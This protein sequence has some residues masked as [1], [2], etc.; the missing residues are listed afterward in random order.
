VVKLLSIRLSSR[1]LL[2]C[3]TSMVLSSAAFAQF[4]GGGFTIVDNGG[5]VPASCSTVPVSGIAV[6]RTITNISFTGVHT[7][8]GDTETRVYPPGAAPPPSTAGSVVISSPPDGRGCNFNGTYN[9]NDTASQSVDAATV[10]C[11][12][13]SDLAPGSYRTSTYG[14]GVNPGP[15]TSL[16]ASFGTLTPAQANGNWLVCIFDFASPDGGAVSSTLIQFNVLTAAN[17]SLSGRVTTAT[18]QGITRAR[19]IISDA[20]GNPRIA[21]TNAFGYY[22]FDDLPAG[23][24]YILSVSAKSYSFA[25]PSQLVNLSD[26]LSGANFVSQN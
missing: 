18:G 17:V 4:S 22:R 5:R 11:A 1:F 20:Q 10:G 2:Y 16:A 26:N 9:Y 6:N 21:I 3:L 8:L 25:S 12:D 14:G 7:W 15:V 13:S 23:Q 24:G 19:L